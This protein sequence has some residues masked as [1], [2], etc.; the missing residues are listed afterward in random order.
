MTMVRGTDSN[1]PSGPQTQPQKMRDMNTMSGLRFMRRPMMRGSS[2]L[3]MIMFTARKIPAVTAAPVQGRG[4]SMIFQTFALYPHLTVE[5]NF[6]YPL[7]REGVDAGEVAKRVQEVAELL[8]VTHTLKRKPSTLSG[9]EQQRV[10][11][12]RALVNRPSLLLA[13]EPTGALDSRTGRAILEL[14]QALNR[15]GITVV[16]VTHDRA[17]ARY[18]GRVLR[19]RDG[20]LVKDRPSA[21]GADTPRPEVM[22]T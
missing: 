4:M 11:I 10:A 1:M 12:A 7:R 9:G 3:P 2:R 14:F 19:L 20:R 6:A 17:V 8:R 15:D 18:A 22:S 13:D 5:Q 21:R 16:L